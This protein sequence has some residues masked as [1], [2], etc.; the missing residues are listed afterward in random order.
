VLDHQLLE[1]DDA[2]AVLQH[3]A[4]LWGYG[5]VLREVDAAAGVVLREHHASAR[6]GIVG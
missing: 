3:L 1:P 5:V 4:D 2:R 6:P